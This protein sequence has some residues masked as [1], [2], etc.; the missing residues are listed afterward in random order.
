MKILFKYFLRGLLFI[1]P[2]GATVFIIAAMVKWVNGSVNKLLSQWLEIG[3]PGLGI[4]IVF[5]A[6]VL[7]GYLFSNTFS[8]PVFRMFERLISK[9]PVVKII[10]TSLKELTEAFV[11]EK[12]KFKEPVMVEMTGAGMYKLGFTTQEDLNNLGISDLVAVYCPHSYNFSGNLFLAPRD[13]ITTLDVNSTDVMKFIV[14]A[15]VTNVRV[16]GKK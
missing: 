15:G 5:F 6:V 9:M 11:G 8:R 12:R 7:V 14:S 13:K 2:V 4:I 1:F 10:Y 16:R 3:I